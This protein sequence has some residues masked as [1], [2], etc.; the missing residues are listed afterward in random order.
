MLPLATDEAESTNGWYPMQE[1]Q[2]IIFVGHSLMNQEK[3]RI[4]DYNPVVSGISL[5]LLIEIW[6]VRKII[7]SSP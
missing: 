3:V 2:S 6:V 4:E 5:F 1:E 7:I